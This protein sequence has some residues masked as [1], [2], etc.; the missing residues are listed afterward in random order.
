MGFGDRGSGFWFRKREGREGGG[1]GERER[2]R[3]VIGLLG[4][5]GVK[6]GLGYRSCWCIGAGY[7]Y[8]G[9]EP[10]HRGWVGYKS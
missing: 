4:I 10:K 6:E 3:V 5:T 7:I 2:K 9:C 8:I 1:K